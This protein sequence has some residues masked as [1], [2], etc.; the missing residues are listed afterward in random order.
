MESCNENIQ[1]GDFKGIMEEY[2]GKQI[3]NK[4]NSQE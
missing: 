1:H 2:N 3:N 4:A